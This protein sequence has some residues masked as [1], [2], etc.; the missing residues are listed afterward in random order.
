M[1]D[2][3]I[4]QSAQRIVQLAKDNIVEYPTHVR[5][6]VSASQNRVLTEQQVTDATQLLESMRSNNRFLSLAYSMTLAELDWSDI[7]SRSRGEFWLLHSTLALNLNLAEVGKQAAERAISELGDSPTSALAKAYSLLGTAARNL[8]EYPSAVVSYTTARRVAQAIDA[9]DLAAWQTFRLGKM[10]VNYLQQPSRGVQYLTQANRDFQ[11]LGTLAAARGEAA[12]LDQLGDVYRETATNLDRAEGLYQAALELNERI[13]NK[14][15]IA[16]NLA[17]LGLCAERRGHYDKARTL[18]ARSVETTAQIVGQDRGVAIRTGQ[19]AK[20]CVECNALDEAR[21]LLE[22]ASSL[23]NRYREF[24]YLAKHE[25]TWGMLCRKERD[26][27]KA[28]VH[29][30]RAAELG[31]QYRLY[32]IQ[33][34]A[35]DQ[36]AEMYS[37]DLQDYSR[38]ERAVLVGSEVRRNAWTY[39]AGASPDLENVEDRLEIAVMYKS[40]FDKLLNDSVSDF[41]RSVSSIRFAY[42]LANRERQ[43]KYENQSRL[44][45]AG[46]V[47]AGIQHEVTNFL[48]EINSTVSGLLRDSRL[49]ESYRKSLQALSDKSLFSLALLRGPTVQSL[50]LTRSTSASRSARAVLPPILDALKRGSESE[51][52]QTIVPEVLPDV[53]FDC[54]PA[55]L[56]LMLA[57]IVQNAKES[58]QLAPAKVITIEVRHSVADGRLAIQIGDSG[59]GM[60]QAQIEDS[61]QVGSSTKPGHVGLGLPTVTFLLESMGGHLE[62]HSTPGIGTT[63]TLIIPTI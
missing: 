49:T 62:L 11:S 56:H 34:E 4:F 32:S 47:M 38:S 17:H 40:L 57:N 15:G 5:S 55:I 1:S 58:M 30:K 10:Y 19:L 42:E 52:V 51:H 53:Q 21:R 8:S 45:A 18:L 29:F 41:D 39:M 12:A 44:F 27:N 16:R 63:M 20:I 13:H 9:R 50:L 24:K 28:E 25:I 37:A 35:H 48:N 61:F 22:Q 31:E 7:P 54:D 2:I 43:A 36:L 59:V 14:K 33:A 6:F 3:D 46:A 23:C 60:T 26:F